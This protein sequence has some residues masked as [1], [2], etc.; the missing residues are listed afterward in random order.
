MT[1]FLCFRVWFQR[2]VGRGGAVVDR[3]YFP[4]WFLCTWELSW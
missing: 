3:L 4:A 1:E 2:Q